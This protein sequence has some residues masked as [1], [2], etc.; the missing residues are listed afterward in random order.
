MDIALSRATMAN[1]VIRSSQDHFE[2]VVRHL[3]REL[4]KREVIHCDETPVHVLKEPSMG[5]ITVL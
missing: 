5:T 1:C 4:L 3:Q 2:P